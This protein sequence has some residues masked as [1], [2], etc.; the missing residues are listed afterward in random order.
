ME[1]YVS[2]TESI[3]CPGEVFRIPNNT[4]TDQE[5]QSKRFI[6]ICT[7]HTEST[8]DDS[9]QSDRYED[10]EEEGLPEVSGFDHGPLGMRFAGGPKPPRAS[11]PGKTRAAPNPFS[12]PDY[13]TVGGV[14]W[15][16]PEYTEVPHSV[17]K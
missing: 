15:K 12:E 8:A 3:Q 4:E 6:E 14:S 11:E 1:A 5:K 7:R 2:I 17:H 16:S 10:D 13:N 9:D